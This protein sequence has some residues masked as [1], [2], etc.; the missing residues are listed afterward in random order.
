MNIIIDNK[1]SYQ[2]GNTNMKIFIKYFP[3][4]IKTDMVSLGKTIL[5]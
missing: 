2:V 5:L 3:H 1:N 4:F